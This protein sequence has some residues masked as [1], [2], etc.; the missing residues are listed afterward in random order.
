[1]R[2]PLTAVLFVILASCGLAATPSKHDVLQAISVLEKNVASPEAVDA[3]KTIVSFAQ[4]SEEVMVD[5]GPDQ[6]PW[7]GEKWGLDKERELA[8]QSMLL[9]AFVAGNIR[10]QIKNDRAEDDTYSGWIFAINIYNRLRAKAAFRSPSLESLS[11]M[12]TDGT[13][14]QHARDIRQKDD[15]AEPADSERRPYT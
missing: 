8:C 3:A 15:K 11:R 10:S 7:V 12:E 14:L 5:I 9:A 4:D 6:I 13:L 2:Q 1:M